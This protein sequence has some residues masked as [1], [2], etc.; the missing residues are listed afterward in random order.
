MDT[1]VITLCYRK[2]IDIN[3]A[4]QWDKVVFEASY[5]EFKMQAQNY[6]H[7]TAF[8]S[9]ADLLKHVPNAKRLA[10][11]VTPAI[12]GY[13][14]QLNGIVPDVLNNVGKRFLKF[15]K[16]QFEIINSDINDKARHQ[17]AVNFYTEALAWH[18][19]IAD[20]LL[21]ADYRPEATGDEEVLSNLF[22]LPPYVNI[23]SLQKLQQHGKDLTRADSPC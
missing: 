16:F 7:G 21:V 1:R 8:T 12:T 13:L 22:K 20:F 23:H 18:D 6:S 17:V 9:Y 10:G 3:S 15:N 5:M 4:K 2:I 19:T 14:Q 11:M